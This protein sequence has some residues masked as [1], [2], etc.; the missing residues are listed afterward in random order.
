MSSGTRSDERYLTIVASVRHARAKPREQTTPRHASRVRG[1]TTLL[2]LLLSALTSSGRIP[3]LALRARNCAATQACCCSTVGAPAP[4]PFL[5]RWRFFLL[6][7][8]GAAV[9]AEPESVGNVDAAGAAAG[10]AVVGMLQNISSSAGVVA[11]VAT[12]A[13][14]FGTAAALVAGVATGAAGAAGPLRPPHALPIGC[15][16]VC[17]PYT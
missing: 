8:T 15:L 2:L 3:S 6:S 9:E 11:G 14:A 1:R 10:V 16:T 17:E 4:R 12:V 5:L 7:S 13:A